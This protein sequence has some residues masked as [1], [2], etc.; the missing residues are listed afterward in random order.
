MTMN[1]SRVWLITGSSAGFGQAIARAALA[2]G[3][4]VVATARRPE[5]LETLVSGTPDH[6]PRSPST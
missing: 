5:T 2:R 3:D 6:V 1:A 4:Q